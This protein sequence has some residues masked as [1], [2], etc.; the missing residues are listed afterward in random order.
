M[1][2]SGDKRPEEGRR[3]DEQDW[4]GDCGYDMDMIEV[5]LRLW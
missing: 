3:A 1:D 2:P 4:A 5:E